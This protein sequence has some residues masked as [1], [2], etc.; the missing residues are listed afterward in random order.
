[1]DSRTQALLASIVL[2]SHDAIVSTTLGGRILTWNHG[3]EILYGYPADE[4]VGRSVDVIVPE[5]RRGD[6]REIVSL[7]SQ[8]ARLERFRTRRIRR[9]GTV[10]TVALA[11]SPLTDAAGA[12]IGVANTA[13]DFSERERAEARFQ[14]VLEAAPDAIVGIDRS[15]EI[16]LANKQTEWIF[17]YA[18][19]ELIRRPV[20]Q[21]V[22][23]GLP[24]DI[25]RAQWGELVPVRGGGE[26]TA[27]R[28]DG[29]TFPVELTISGLETE[30]GPVACLVLR[31]ITERLQAQAEQDR[32][33][34]EAERERIEARMHRTQRLESLG[35]LAGGVA[36]DFNNLLAVIMNY[37]TFVIEEAEAQQ[38]DVVAIRRDGEQIVRASKRGTELTHQLLAFA[39]REVVRPRVLD[40]NQVILDVEQMLRRSIGE[41]ITLT[42]TL[43]A[44]LP[45]VTADPGQIEQVLV[46]LAVN[47]RDAMPS[48]GQLTIFTGAVDLDAD[49]AANRPGLDPGRY[50]RIAVSDTGAGMSKEVVDRAFEPFYTTKR[51]GEGTGLGLATV[52]GIVTQA[53]GSVQIYSEP[54]L[55]TTVSILLPVTDEPSAVAAASAPEPE[56]AHQGNGETILVVE[57]EPALRDLACRILDG[58]GYRVLSAE[59]GQDALKLATSGIDLLLTDVI[60]PGMLGKEL[61]D[62][63]TARDPELRVLYMSGYAQPILASRGTLDPGVS[64]IEKPFGKAELLTAV[65]LQLD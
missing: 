49:H 63:L 58:A 50:V 27:L 38:P 11:V 6:E 33:R 15:G 12:I 28:K 65:R 55:G 8:G 60:M 31:D 26:G 44:G 40:L 29:S 9:D 14:A 62:R 42:T 24:D 35:Q 5:D 2:S 37:G 16:V 22:V 20:A 30:D 45:V 53:H 23:A 3:A 52:Y 21:L 46:N 13:R 51:S 19:H 57:D 36:H 4:M 34:A 18:K 61:A 47:A 54:G 48:G 56:P 7:V 39:R 41:H 10:I 1:M 64:L 32:L 59:S 43:A 25:W 17:G